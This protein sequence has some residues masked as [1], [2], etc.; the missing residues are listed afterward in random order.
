MTRLI[1]ATVL[2]LLSFK[3]T[4]T[5][6]KLNKFR[7]LGSSVMLGPQLLLLGDMEEMGKLLGD[8]QGLLADENYN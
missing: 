4:C 1:H 5:E 2:E 3:V 7:V 6:S 8:S